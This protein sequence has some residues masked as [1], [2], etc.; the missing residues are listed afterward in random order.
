MMWTRTALLIRSSS[1]GGGGAGNF[2][3]FVTSRYFI[4]S[5]FKI[6]V[7]S[8]GINLALQERFRPPSRISTQSL[9]ERYYLPSKLS[10]FE[11]VTLLMLEEAALLQP[12]QEP[13]LFLSNPRFNKNMDDIGV[14]WLEYH[15]PRRLVGLDIQNE[16]N[17]TASIRRILHLNHGFG[18]SSLSWLPALPILV[19]RLNCDVG[20]AHDAP[21]FGFTNRRRQNNHDDD[22]Y[23][24]TKRSAKIGLALLLKASAANSPVHQSSHGNDVVTVLMG[25][26][27]GSLTTLRMVLDLVRKNEQKDKLFNITKCHVVLVAPVFRPTS[28]KRSTRTSSTVTPSSKATDAP[29][30]GRAGRFSWLSDLRRRLGRLAVDQPA[31]YALRR[32]VSQASSKNKKNGF[33]R[34]GLGT[35]WGDATR[36][37]DA[38]ILRFQWPSIGQGWEDG[39]I[40]FSKAQFASSSSS[41]ASRDSGSNNHDHDNDDA[42]SI[43]QQLMTTVHPQVTVD[44]IVGEKDPLVPVK[45]IDKF[46]ADFMST[47][48]SDKNAVRVR[49]LP[50]LG[51]DPFEEDVEAF[52][53]TLE[54]LLSSLPL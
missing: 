34:R 44:V 28:P 33:W 7:L 4:G 53:V 29:S 47:N 11:N 23:Y 10:R 48:G 51:H 41:S 13:S 19:E 16:R 1:S 24:T 52:A 22:E 45:S 27:M 12:Q 5:V 38:D 31:A 50:G 17:T 9:M 39:L 6:F 8:F 40:Q 43:L 21:G 2:F 18:A 30:R 42:R 25:H 37:S 14:H 46:F 35:V 26:S 20:L 32:L 36:L 15:N 3:R 54:D 49:V